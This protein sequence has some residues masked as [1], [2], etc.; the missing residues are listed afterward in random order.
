MSVE[1]DGQVL[2]GLHL[3]TESRVM[4]DGYMS[5]FI[6]TNEDA[7]AKVLAAGFRRPGPITPAQFGAALVEYQDAWHDADR[8][9]R[10]GQRSREGLLAA[11]KS[12]GIEVSDGR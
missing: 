11:L 6:G 3:A 9:G 4:S 12:L 7:A 10:V 2:L 1:E 8:A 5:T